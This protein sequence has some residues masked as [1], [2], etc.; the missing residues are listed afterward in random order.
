MKIAYLLASSGLSGGVKVVLQQAEE[1]AA[2]GHRVTVVCPDP[3]PSWFPRRRFAWEESAFPA[4]RALRESDVAVATFWSTV[5]PAVAHGGGLVFHL[6]QGYEA[7]FAGYG[8]VRDRI[9]EA[10]GLPTRKLALT[11][12]LRETL[13]ERGHGDAEVIGQSFDASPFA[14]APRPER[15]PLAILL[16]GID[17]GEVKITPP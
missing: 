6:C 5:E 4:S 9:L 13:R 8:G 11:P 12:A 1:L 2:R 10:Y 14:C 7:D 17:E 16:P 3:A 15:A